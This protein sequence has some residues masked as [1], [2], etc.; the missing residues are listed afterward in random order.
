MFLASFDSLTI[1][2]N[3]HKELTE[4][5][6]HGVFRSCQVP[7]SKLSSHCHDVM[8]PP[9]FISDLVSRF[10]EGGIFILF[11]QFADFQLLNGTLP[12]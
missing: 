10:S 1:S 2:F 11:G 4:T 5:I 12:S 3:A 9:V 6:R 8:L 7:R